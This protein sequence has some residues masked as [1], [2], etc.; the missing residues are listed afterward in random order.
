MQQQHRQQRQ[1]ETMSTKLQQQQQQHEQ[2][3]S[4]V[5]QT[6]KAQLSC[7]AIWRGHKRLRFRC[8]NLIAV[9]FCDSIFELWKKKK[10][11]QQQHIC[12]LLC[13]RKRS[14]CNKALHNARLQTFFL[15]FLDFYLPTFVVVAVFFLTLFVCLQAACWQFCGFAY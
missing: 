5:R 4:A 13:V 6:D 12:H 10:K 11:I 2:C 3:K 9:I 7:K 14:N 8:I 15:I 1:Q